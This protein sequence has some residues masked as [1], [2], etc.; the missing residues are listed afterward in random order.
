MVVKMPEK[1]KEVVLLLASHPTW[2]NADIAAHLGKS[3]RTIQN[4]LNRAYKRHGLCHLSDCAKRIQIILKYQGEMKMYKKSYIAQI[5]KQ[6]FQ[7][8]SGLASDP[9]T[10]IRARALRLINPSAAEFWTNEDTDLILSQIKKQIPLEVI[11][12]RF[13]YNQLRDMFGEDFASYVKS[14]IKH[15]IPRLKTGEM[16]NMDGEYVLYG[17]HYELA[18]RQEKYGNIYRILPT[19]AQLREMPDEIVKALYSNHLKISRS[20]KN[21]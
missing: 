5:Y 9:N 4:Q 21:V 1:E 2:S 6:A 11:T 10:V 3:E 17:E 12:Q 7:N 14:E 16:S 19:R 18:M 15:D 20:S 8:N 13:S